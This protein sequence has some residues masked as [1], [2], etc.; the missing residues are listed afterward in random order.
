MYNEYKL[1]CVL[2]QLLLMAL[3]PW[4]WTFW[5]ILRDVK[6][7]KMMKKLQFFQIV[8][9]WKYL[10]IYWKYLLGDE[11]E[12]SQCLQYCSY[13]LIISLS[14]HDSIICGLLKHQKVTLPCVCVLFIPTASFSLSRYVYL[15]KFLKCA[16]WIIWLNWTPWG[17]IQF[18]QSYW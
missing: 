6:T 10:F 11:N 8:R 2:I 3:F 13:W 5:L 1:W 4:S 15:C 12:T 9:R 18:D 7:W 14:S 17:F 16:I